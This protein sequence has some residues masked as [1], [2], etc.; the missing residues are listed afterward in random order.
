[1]LLAVLADI[2]GNREALEACLTDARANGADRLVFLGDYVGYGPDPEA[3]VER[4]AAEVERGA[5][6]V[7]GNHDEAIGVPDVHMNDLARRSIEWTRRQ[8]GA[9]HR[10]FLARLPLSH[11]D[12][13]LLFVHAD[14]SN[15][16]RW[17]YVTG[18]DEAQR[19]IRAAPRRVTLCG[20]VHVPAIYSMSEAWKL[21]S[22]RPVADVAVPLLPQRRWLAV[23]GAVGQP[24]D[25][26]PAAAYALLDSERGELTTRRVPYD[27]ETVGR[28]ILERGLPA[29]L[30]ERLRLGT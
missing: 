11:D 29:A 8:L 22:F 20:H 23:L 10:A 21:T 16:K 14:P 12:A 13:G 5:A 18:P 19:A 17:I 25:G 26:N 28:K 1:M 6:A 3:C 15:P 30:A 4:V 7:L 2:H 9:D 27:V 24:R